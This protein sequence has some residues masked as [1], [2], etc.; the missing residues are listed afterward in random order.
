MK[1]RIIEQL[2]HIE[3]K[4]NV[5]ILYAV[6]SGSR[7]WGLASETSDY[8]VRFIYIHEKDWYLSIDPQGSGAK[9]DVIHLPINEV[10]DI[11]GWEVTKA[12]RL[13]RKSNPSLLEWLHSNTVYLQASSFAE[14]LKEQESLVFSPTSS[15]HHYLNMALSNYKMCLQHRNKD[16]VKMVINCLRPILACNWI[17]K[18]NSAPPVDF[19]ILVNSSIPIGKLKKEIEELRYKKI[20]GD[21]TPLNPNNEILPFIAQQLEH[22]ESLTKTLTTNHEDSTETLNDLFRN[23]LHEVWNQL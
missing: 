13:F 1:K 17:E 8:D 4:F 12:L 7:A 16:Q 19:Q 9:R 11:S 21:G 3:K 20:M 23:T 22:I 14:H 15:L 5:K 2:N 10:L 18:Y 6:D